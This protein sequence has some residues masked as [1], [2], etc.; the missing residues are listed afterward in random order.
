MYISIS[1]RTIQEYTT[2][3]YDIDDRFPPNLLLDDLFPPPAHI[4]V[5]A[6]GD[7]KL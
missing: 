1:I 5:W 2:S 3:T 6:E 4:D 7:E